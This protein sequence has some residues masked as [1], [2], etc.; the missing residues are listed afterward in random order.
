[1]KFERFG[2]FWRHYEDGFG[3]KNDEKRG[4]RNAFGEIIEQILTHE[5]RFISE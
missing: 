3:V 4:K 1:M 2:S 5:R